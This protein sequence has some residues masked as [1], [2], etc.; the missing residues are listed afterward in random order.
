MTHWGESS[1]LPKDF[2]TGMCGIVHFS[3][4]YRRRRTITEENEGAMT[5][6]TLSLAL[7]THIISINYYG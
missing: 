2:W 3:R 4:D 6:F 7:Q 5:A 1:I